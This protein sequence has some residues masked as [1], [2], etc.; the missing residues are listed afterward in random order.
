MALSPTTGNPPAV[1]H[2][3]IE[4][5]TK[6]ADD[7]T[8]AMTMGGQQGLDFL[9]NI[10]AEWCEAVDDVNTAR[11]I[12][13]DMA[14]RGL[15]HEAINWHALGFFDVADRLD[16]DRPGW[17]VWESSLR[18][19]GIITPRVDGE[20]KEMANRIHEDLQ[21]ADVS[22]RSLEEYLVQ[23][24]RNMLQRGHLGERL[25]ILESIRGL[26]P[27]GGTWQAMMQP[28]KRRRVDAIADEVKAAVARRDF[29]ALAAL[30]TEV[31]SQ[32]WEGGLPAG[33]AKL[34]E[35]TVPCEALGE[36]RSQ[37]SRAA[38]TLV[39]SVEEARRHSAAG[40][41]TSLEEATRDRER[42]TELRAS[43][44]AIIKSATSTP[45]ATAIVVES[46]VKDVMGKLDAATQES[47]LWLDQQADL[48]ATR[49]EA[50]KIE[51]ALQKQIEAA[52]AKG[53]NKEDFE[54]QL[55]IWKRS[56]EQCL[57]K[58]RRRAA[59]LPG[60]VP[61]STADAIQKLCDT[62]QHQEAHLK[63]LKWREKLIL[64]IF[65]GVFG[66]LLLILVIAIAI[67][68]AVG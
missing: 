42:Y 64:L 46:G 44:N 48:A 26:D 25:V 29:E 14:D 62:R 11:Q 54:R 27:A 18:E 32:D 9:M 55:R 3:Q 52:P 24:R 22:G 39:G 23:L 15:R 51:A 8:S 10:M 41:A 49:H 37:L 7:V 1:T 12:C 36:L 58:A 28:I 59:S 16:P 53:S 4:A 34:L 13:V 45:E 21:L 6:L 67:S 60:G 30:R 47:C 66:G 31:T 68:L 50:A 43:L 17:E 63:E 38:A 20:L 2:E 65:L 57:E 33:V 5:W 56:T 19:Q 40:G 35:S 61:A